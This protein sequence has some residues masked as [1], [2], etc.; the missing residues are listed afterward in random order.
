MNLADD[1][2]IRGLGGHLSEPQS[3]PLM[4]VRDSVGPL[5]GVGFIGTGFNGD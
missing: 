5:Y 2:G 3:L 1:T 4:K